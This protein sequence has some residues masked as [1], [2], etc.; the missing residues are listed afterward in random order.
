MGSCLPSTLERRFRAPK[1][2]VF[3]NGNAGL[4]FSCGQTKTEV[5]KNADVHS[6]PQSPS[7]LGHMVEWLWER[8]RSYSAC[9]I[10]DVIVFPSFQRFRV[11]G[12]NDSNNYVWTR[13]FSKTKKKISVFK[14]I[15]IR[16]DEA[17][18][19]MPQLPWVTQQLV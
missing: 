17:S 8:E 5:F 18:V 10:R 7:F 19:F 1:M 4:S 15:R 11:D 12:Q 3:G 16:V 2:Q 9:P 14:S 13:I 6:R